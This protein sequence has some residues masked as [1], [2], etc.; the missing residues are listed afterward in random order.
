M[1][2]TMSLVMMVFM[3]VPI[4]APALGQILISFTDWSFIF[5]FMSVLCAAVTLW[6]FLKLP[7][8]LAPEHR[9]PLTPASIWE[10]FRLVLSNRTT[11]FYTLAT[12]FFFGSLFGFLNTTQPIY[13]EIYG[14][15]ALFPAAFGG[16]G[17]LMALSSYT[18]SRLVGYFGQ[19]RLSH[20]A[21][22]GFLLFG[23][24]LTAVSIG[25]NPPFWLFMGLIAIGMPM[26][27]LIGSNFNA[28]AMEPLGAVAG[29][30]SSVVG[31]LQTVGGAATGAVIGQMYAGT[32]LPLAAGF[33]AVSAIAVIMVLIAEKGRL[34]GTGSTH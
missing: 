15:G 3:V 33:A 4:V 1:A 10:G 26:F 28:I 24:V 21:L 5:V 11:M 13:V 9:R 31:F 32:V 2:A 25:G 17:V 23:L 34:F 29:T 16:I 27:G 19:R 12:T 20:G 18:N 7:E 8:T 14:L 22:L 6:S 30:A